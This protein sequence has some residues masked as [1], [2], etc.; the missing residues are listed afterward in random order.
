MILAGDLGGTK[1]LL[2]LY[3]KDN[4]VLVR[5]DVECYQST[6]FACLSDIIKT[7]LRP[8][9]SVKV[10][11]AC[12]G[13]PGPVIDG[14]AHITNLPWTARENEIAVAADTEKVRLVN[15]L[16]AMTTA[17]PH[18]K[19][20]DVEVLYQGEAPRR[21]ATCAVIAPGTG[22]GQA[23]L[24]WDEA[25]QRHVVHGSE[26]GH[27][28]F[29]PTNDTE[30]ALLSYL[31]RK[32]G[33]VSYERI[34]SGPGLVNVY[35]FLLAEG[36]FSEPGILKKRLRSGDRAAVISKAGIDGEFD[37][38]MATLDIFASVLG[39]QAANQV[40]SL[41]ARGGV[42]LGGGI[43]PKIIKKLTDGTLLKS[44]LNK[45][46]LTDMCGETSIFVIKDDHAPLLGAAT[47]AA[48][49]EN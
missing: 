46:R 38:C 3:E 36:T 11:F 29:A 14:E 27:S 32:F 45:G 47:I 23:I 33:H 9:S 20:D 18:F 48:A 2:S 26:G 5:K 41:L 25:A 28:A 15:D 31:T 13:A 37:I 6:E 16:V 21:N 10:D 1:T 4:D 8:K 42:Y 39:T 19:E 49:L 7:Y 22:L 44:Y 12:I 43:P 24:F 40:V 34:L 17:I 30:A 35:D